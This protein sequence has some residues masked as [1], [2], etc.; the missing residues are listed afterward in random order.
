MGKEIDQY[1]CALECQTSDNCTIGCCSLST[2]RGSTHTT[3]GYEVSGKTFSLT[4]TMSLA[5]TSSFHFS[6]VLVCKMAS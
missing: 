3:A 2:R 1:Y 4:M 5:I 6:S